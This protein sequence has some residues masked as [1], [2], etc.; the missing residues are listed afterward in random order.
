MRDA[1]VKQAVAPKLIDLLRSGKDA[2]RKETLGA[3]AILTEHG[4]FPMPS[5]IHGRPLSI[6]LDQDS[7]D[8]IVVGAVETLYP[9]MNSNPDAIKTLANLAIHS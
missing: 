6:Q 5:S 3:L 1:L 8:L 7:T 9:L 4:T 2:V